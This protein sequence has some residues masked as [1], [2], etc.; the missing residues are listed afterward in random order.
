MGL[1]GTLAWKRAW[2]REGGGGGLAFFVYLD[3]LSTGRGVKGEVIKMWWTSSLCF[4]LLFASR[5][6][7]E[8]SHVMY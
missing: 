8:N 5:K 4:T 1:R 3:V 6:C 7:Y 2:R